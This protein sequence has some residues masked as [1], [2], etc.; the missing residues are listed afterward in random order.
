MLALTVPPSALA[1]DVLLAQVTYS[2]GLDPSPPAPPGG[3]TR[4]RQEV[5]G[6]RATSAV[7]LRVAVAGDAGTT[8]TFRH[9]DNRYPMVGGIVAYSG[10]STGNPVD[11]TGL[12]AQ[13]SATARTPSVTTATTN[14]LLVHF[15]TKVEDDLPAPSGTT[16]RWGARSEDGGNDWYAIRA[17]DVPFPGSGTGP[18]HQTTSATNL[19]TPWTVQT[20]ALRRDPGTPSAALSWTPSSSSWASG[21][22]LERSAGG[23]V[24]STRTVTSAGTASATEGPLVNGVT[25]TFRLWAHRGAWVSPDVTTTLTP[26]C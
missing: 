21:Y 13:T 25:Y 14:T 8:V 12:A 9:S 19:A 6:G 2:G 10:V 15:L 17:F 11:V 16:G 7:Y 26:S 1:A 20:V 18:V 24:Q 3:W 5:L 22:R 4:L 23:A